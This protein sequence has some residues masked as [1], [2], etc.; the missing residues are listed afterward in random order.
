[1][2]TSHHLPAKKRRLAKKSCQYNRPKISFPHKN[3]SISHTQKREENKKRRRDI[4]FSTRSFPTPFNP[5]PSYHTSLSPPHLI[6]LKRET[7]FHPFPEIGNPLL[8]V[9][10][11]IF[12][13]ADQIEGGEK[14]FYGRSNVIL[15]PSYLI[16][17]YF[18]GAHT[19]ISLPFPSR[20]GNFPSFP[21]HFLLLR[22]G[23]KE[24]GII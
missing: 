20:S 18:S 9:E 19:A 23:G 6:Y 5:F 15:S 4:F 12:F 8:S 24:V 7:D 16:F 1:M 11:F 17:F 14:M 13:P 21:F 3:G 10:H 22:K 2:V